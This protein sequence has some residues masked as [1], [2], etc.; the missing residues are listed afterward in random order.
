MARPWP[1]RL[2]N[3]A[4][5]PNYAHFARVPGC[6]PSR[7]AASRRVKSLCIRYLLVVC[8]GKNDA[9]ARQLI[10]WGKRKLGALPV[11][12][13]GAS[14]AESNPSLSV[15]P[16]YLASLVLG[17]NRTAWLVTFRTGDAR[18]NAFLDAP[19]SSPD[20][21]YHMPYKPVNTDRTQARPPILDPYTYAYVRY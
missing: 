13:S 4:T 5:M 3:F 8:D 18:I 14:D 16:L 10:I 2:K 1:P 21:W 12:M 19:A 7:W 15:D 20:Q 11:Y 9:D 6:T 17:V